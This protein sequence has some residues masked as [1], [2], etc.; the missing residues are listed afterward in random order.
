MQSE[1]T[2]VSQHTP[3][4]DSSAAQPSSTQ[5]GDDFADGPVSGPLH[6]EAVEGFAVLDQTTPGSKCPPLSHA[7]VAPPSSPASRVIQHEN[8]GTPGRRGAEL[9]FRVVASAAQSMQA[10]ESLPNGMFDPKYPADHLQVTI[11]RRGSHPYPVASASSVPFG[12]HPCV[13]SV[14]CPGHYSSC[15][16]NRLLPVLP[17][18]SC[19][20]EWASRPHG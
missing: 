11:P 4:V 5:H 16:E 14:P 8:A 3:S 18:S 17:W 2:A 13:S 9:G 10:L 1:P 6:R 7:D 20:R 15:L 12:Y 19:C